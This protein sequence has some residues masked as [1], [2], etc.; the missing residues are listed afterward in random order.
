MMFLYSRVIPD[1]FLVVLWALV[2]SYLFYLSSK[3]KT[4]SGIK[5]LAYGL[6]SKVLVVTFLYSE[7]LCCT[8]WKKFFCVCACVFLPIVFTELSSVLTQLLTKQRQR[9]WRMNGGSCRD[10]RKESGG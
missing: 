3:N 6:Q 1:A 5:L 10:G 8:W 7:F 2:L 9:R 4:A